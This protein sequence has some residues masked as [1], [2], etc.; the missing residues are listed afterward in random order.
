VTREKAHAIVALRAVLDTSQT[1]DATGPEWDQLA[2]RVRGIRGDLEMM[3][4]GRRAA[5]S[6][7]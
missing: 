6:E 7:E 5:E 4:K 1:D 2:A 3:I